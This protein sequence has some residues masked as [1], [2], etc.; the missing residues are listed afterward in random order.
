MG[1]AVQVAKLIEGALCGDTAKVLAYAELIAK[2]F[3]QDSDARSAR[4]VRRAIGTEPPGRPVVLDVAACPVCH[5]PV[6]T[7]CFCDYHTR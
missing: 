2:H 4:I 6:A 7:G 5:A 3:E 1:N